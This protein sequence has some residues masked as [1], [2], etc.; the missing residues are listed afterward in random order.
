M[1]YPG[2]VDL[3]VL[4]SAMATLMALLWGMGV[5][6]MQV[7]AWVYNQGLVVTAG[8]MKLE[9]ASKCLV[10]C[11][12]LYLSS[13]TADFPLCQSFLPLFLPSALFLSH[14]LF[15]TLC[16]HL[17]CSSLLPS[18]NLSSRLPFIALTMA[19]PRGIVPLWHSPMKCATMGEAAA[20][21]MAST[22]GAHELKDEMEMRMRVLGVQLEETRRELAATRGE[23]KEAE[24]RQVV[25]MREMRG[26]VEERE[27]EL[28]AKLASMNGEVVTV[29]GEL[30]TVKG[31][32]AEHKQSS[33][34]QL[35]EAER[36]RVDEMRDMKGQV[37]ER[38]RALISHQDAIAEQVNIAERR[39]AEDLREL[40]GEVQERKRTLAALKWELDEAE[41]RRAV[42][43]RELRGQVE[44]RKR[45]LEEVERRRVA[46]MREMRGEVEER[47]EEMAAEL[48]AVEGELGAVKGRLAEQKQ[49]TAVQLE[50]AERR[51]AAQMREMRGQVGAVKGEVAE[52]KDS[53]KEQ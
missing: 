28:I 51:R 50:E 14:T 6:P 13:T 26:Q 15:C 12:A 22:A 37:E 32:L 39:R 40:R 33:T 34:F 3:L 43:M 19:Q 38:E 9:N 20:I 25:E 5:T 27:R 45:G 21:V 2:A 29:K 11:R 47:G 48:A 52:H 7:R 4:W 44:E 31:E 23:L 10:V 1:Q 46:E 16:L 24:R 30:T 41:R 17:A 35:E 18:L 49:S 36:R 42:E 8:L 53:M